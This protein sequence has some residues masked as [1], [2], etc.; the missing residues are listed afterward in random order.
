MEV[1]VLGPVAVRV[2]GAE[3]PLGTPRQRALVSALAL[4]G[5]RPVS[6]D[7][8]VELLWAGAPP[9][10]VATTLQTYV[11]G[12]RRVLEPERQRRAPATVLVT[13]APG[14]ALRVPDLDASRFEAAV[15]TVHQLLGPHGGMGVG[16]AGVAGTVAAPL[17]QQDLEAAVATLDE[18]LSWWRGTPY[19]E[20]ADAPDAVAARARLEELR[21][22]AQEDRARAGLALGRHATVAAELDALTAAHPLRERLW[23]LRAL[24]LTRSGR[25]ADA[26]EVLRTVRDVLD[27]E[28]GLEP[29]TELRDLQTAILRQDPALAWV[30]PPSAAG[31]VP[32]QRDADADLVPP[33]S[34]EAPGPPT[35]TG[36]AGTPT[37]SPRDPAT[38]EAVAPWRMVGRDAQLAALRAT[39]AAARGGRPSLAVVTG[40]PGIGK[41]R[42]AQELAATAR[43]TGVVVAVG[44]G[45]QDDGAPP[46]WPWSSVLRDLGL[47]LPGW[48]GEDEG[49]R[50]RAW[51]QITRQVR[52]AAGP[53]PLLVVL[54]DLHWVD[55]SS[56]RVLRLLAETMADEPLMVLCTWR[57]HPPP[58]GALAD[59]AETLARQHALRI[60]LAG[61]A[62]GEVAQVVGELTRSQPSTSQAEALY[63]RTDGNPF[64]LVEFARLAGERGDLTKLLAEEDPPTAVSEVIRRRLSRLSAET[65]AALGTASVAGRSFDTATV[66]KVTGIA[67]DD[68]LDVVEPAVAAGLVREEG[69]DRFAFAHAL[70]RD[71]LYAATS[72]S[73]RA[74]THVRV[75]RALAGQPGRETEVA[76]HWLAGGPAHAAQAWRAAVAAAEVTARLHA[77]DQTV[78][79]L[80]AALERMD[81]DLVPDLTPLDRYDVVMRLVEAY[82]WSAMWPEL[83]GSV[84][85]AV[86]LARRM[87]D[88]PRAVRAA[89]STTMGALW[90]S[91]PDGAENPEVVG[92]LR[93]A[94]RRLPEEDSPLRCRAMLALA[95]E[96][97][98]GRARGESRDLV[99]RALAM[100]VR[101]GDPALLLDAYQVAF[102]ALWSPATALRRLDWAEESLRLARETGNERAVVVS[103]T[104]RVVVLSE[105]GR[106][107]EARVAAD[108][109]RRESERLRIAYGPMILD[110][111]AA[112]WEAMA[113]R[114][115][116]CD[117]LLAAMRRLAVD[118]HLHDAEEGHTWARLAVALWRG[119]LEELLPVVRELGEHP[120]ATGLVVVC[121]H[122]AGQEAEARAWYADHALDLDHDEG[123]SLL[124]WGM[125][126]EAAVLVGDPDVGRDAGSRLAPYAGRCCM[127]GSALACGP[128]DLYL[129]YAA[130]AAG[131]R[132][133]AARHADRAAELCA[134]W[135]IPLPARR[136]ERLRAEHGF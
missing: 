136:L 82:R 132:E 61:L 56:L 44:R 98:G 30:R 125:A 127:G 117:R 47:E 115:E 109:A 131:D 66:S 81:P 48:E 119:G 32:V 42:L 2:D 35:V 60:E 45:S 124:M 95:N 72:A 3:V 17:T 37:T 89:A 101:L 50:F 62:P 69:L 46:L 116:E 104:L 22:V 123:E 102:M 31:S 53:A 23:A 16:G 51:E 14:Y 9:P 10:G 70:V 129:A 79:L 113:G 121:L 97:E 93:E 108:L 103:A 77:H 5:G 83:V 126:A 128:V 87:D 58:A 43:A 112:G 13:V 78:E 118:R 91:A 100:A 33:G 39:L 84:E 15:G 7:A 24:A 65:V 67:E 11:S 122:R 28:L 40:E 29:G 41:T 21:L 75:A 96:Q 74:R 106:P 120:P 134:E 130:A 114:F 90:R 6:V 52:A 107:A 63:A 133:A 54:D 25:Q 1:A 88:V 12:L 18:A 34:P 27:A 36:P 86:A 8:L 73:R 135:G 38:V 19:A 64:F 92:T 68:L 80:R 99:D 105:L 4:S 49:A 71:T 59:V 55:T 94:L 110:S 111:I 26:L 85:Q 76:H 20:L 57:R